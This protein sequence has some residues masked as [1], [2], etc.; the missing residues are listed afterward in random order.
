MVAVEHLD[1][2]KIE[3][4]LHKHGI[5]SVSDYAPKKVPLLS[6]WAQAGKGEG[7]VRWRG[8]RSA[9]RGGGGSEPWSTT[10]TSRASSRTLP[11][12]EPPGTHCAVIR[13]CCITTEAMGAFD[14]HTG[15]HT[16]TD[17]LFFVY[18][19]GTVCASLAAIVISRLVS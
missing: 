1:E 2:K 12:P 3:E 5:E 13:A 6:S 11:P 18:I 7:R 9:R 8:A 16:F 17:K 14:G 4:Y 19:G 15:G 10:S